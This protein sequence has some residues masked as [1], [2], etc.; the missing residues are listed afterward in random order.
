MTLFQILAL[1]MAPRPFYYHLKMDLGLKNMPSLPHGL[2]KE[3]YT[4]DS[5]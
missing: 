5:P 2:E 3:Y 4:C 1:S